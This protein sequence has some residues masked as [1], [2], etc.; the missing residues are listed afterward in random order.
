M[1]TF[2]PKILVVED[3]PAM[4]RLLCEV[5]S[6]SG[7]EPRCLTSSREAAELTN[8]EKFHAVFLDWRSPN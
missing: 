2:K 5:L 4:L 6:R 1:P 8:R 3:D 7:A